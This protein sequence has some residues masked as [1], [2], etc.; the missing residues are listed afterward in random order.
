MATL[1]VLFILIIGLSA[2]GAEADGIVSTEV[3]GTQLKVSLASGR[4]LWSPVLV[5]AVLNL[6]LPDGTT[7]RVRIEQVEKDPQD[8]DGDV[9]LH[10]LLVAQSPTDWADL[11]GPDAS[12]ARWAFPLRGQWNNEG[13]RTSESGFTLICASGAIGKCVRMGYK[14]WKTTTEGISLAAY[15]TACVKAVR[16][17][18]CGNKG[19]TRDGQLIDISDALGIQRSDEG[20]GSTAMPFEAA[21]SEEGAVC[22]AHTRVPE[23]VTLDALAAQ[24]P[25]LAGRLGPQACIESNAVNGRYGTP[26]IFIRSPKGGR[27]QDPPQA[28]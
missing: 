22:V 28:Q 2:R 17:D 19:T 27:S 23:N 11:C 14:P 1:L 7:G 25:R 10:R 9:F 21:F 15:H 5:G 6:G 3:E 24:C 4:R 18:Y 26:M 8:P 16:A 13:Q 12:G 20:Q